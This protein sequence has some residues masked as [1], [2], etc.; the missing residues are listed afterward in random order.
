MQVSK[1]FPLHSTRPESP[2]TRTKW[3]CQLATVHIC[4]LPLKKKKE[5]CEGREVGLLL[6]CSLNLDLG[7]GLRLG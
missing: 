5:A 3:I 1:E 6:L 7:S 4:H 2:L